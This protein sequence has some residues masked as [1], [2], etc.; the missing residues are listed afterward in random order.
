MSRDKK[1][2]PWHVVTWR[3]TYRNKVSI[4]KPISFPFLRQPDHPGP[5]LFEMSFIKSCSLLKKIHPLAQQTI[6]ILPIYQGGCWWYEFLSSLNR[7]DSHR[8]TLFYFF[9]S[10]LLVIKIVEGVEEEEEI[11][12]SKKEEG[13]LQ[14]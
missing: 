1:I 10:L 12:H 8:V 9:H 7:I 14:R 11:G 6:I 2:V 13:V 4:H 3:F 5:L